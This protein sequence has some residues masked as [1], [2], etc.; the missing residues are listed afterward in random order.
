MQKR[1]CILASALLLAHMALAQE[2]SAL[3][4]RVIPAFKWTTESIPYGDI[5][6][7]NE[8]TAIA[9]ITITT[10]SIGAPP[11]R[12]DAPSGIGDLSQHLTVFPP[13]MIIPPG[14]TR[15]LRYAIMDTSPLD[16]GGHAALIKA[17]FARRTPVDQLQTP[18]AATALRLNYELVVPLIL[19]KGVGEPEIVAKIASQDADKLILDLNNHGNSPWAGTVYLSS[20]D[21]QQSFGSQTGVIFL[22]REIEIALLTPL[23]DTFRVV[24][25][26]D[27]DWTPE[28]SLRTPDPIL[29]SR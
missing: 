12:P 28:H 24:F 4:L 9:E 5:R 14:E 23:P 7:T 17:R 6:L 3:A 26:S 27:L 15:I 10:T 19:L 20:E 18:S 13:R 2:K 11:G 29:V 22:Q 16:E 8:G 25:E 1:F 21:G